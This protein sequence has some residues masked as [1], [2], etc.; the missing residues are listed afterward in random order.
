M[1]QQPLLHRWVPAQPTARA[2]TSYPGTYI[3][4]NVDITLYITTDKDRVIIAGRGLPATALTPTREMD[5]FQ[6]SGFSSNY[7]LSF[8]RDD[9]GRVIGI[10]LDAARVRGMHFLRADKR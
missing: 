2:L 1:L 10:S 8:L 5:H 7:G 9:G 6:L 3:G 4:E